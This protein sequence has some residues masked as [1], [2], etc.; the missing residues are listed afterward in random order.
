MEEYCKFH[1]IVVNFKTTSVVGIF[2]IITII[3][4]IILNTIKYIKP[5]R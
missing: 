5:E 4:I 2:G 1:F 3:S